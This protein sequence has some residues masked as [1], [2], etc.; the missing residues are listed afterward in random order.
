MANIKLKDE[1]R[2]KARN[3]ML[4]DVEHQ[5][6]CDQDPSGDGRFCAGLREM[7]KRLGY[8]NPTL[9]DMAAKRPKGKKIAA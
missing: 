7:L 3:T 2:R 1:F 5:F 4:N 6:I 8:K 9:Q